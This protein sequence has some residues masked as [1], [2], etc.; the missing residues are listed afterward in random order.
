MNLFQLHEQSKYMMVG[1]STCIIE[2][3]RVRRRAVLCTYTLLAFTTIHS[4]AKVVEKNNFF[5]NGISSLSHEQIFHLLPDI[6]AEV[7]MGHSFKPN[8]TST[9]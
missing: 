8:G 2:S 3:Y 1:S 9:N 4:P 6:F 7:C 5:S